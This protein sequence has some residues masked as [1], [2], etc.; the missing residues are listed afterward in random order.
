MELVQIST[1]NGIGPYNIY[2][3]DIS[4]I[5]CQTIDTSVSTFP[6]SFVLPAPFIGVNSIIIKILDLGSGCEKFIPYYCPDISC[7]ILT[8]TVFPIITEDSFN[9]ITEDC[10]V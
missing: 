3:C 5:Y 1:V 8:E 2:A 10:V 4:L 7:Y 6:Y 9:L